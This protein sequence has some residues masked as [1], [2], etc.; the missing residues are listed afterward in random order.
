MCG[1]SKCQALF[2]HQ[3][4]QYVGDNLCICLKSTFIS[5]HLDVPPVGVIRRD[6]TVMHYGIVQQSK[7]MSSAPPSRCV[8]RIASMCRPGIPFVFI[9]P[10]EPA[11]IL[12]IAYRLECAHVLSAGEHI[13]PV[14]L[15][16]YVHHRTRY[17]FFLVELELSE[18]GSKRIDKI[19]PDHRLVSDLRYLSRRDTLRVDDLKILLQKCL[20]LLSCVSAVKKQMERI[21]ILVIRINTIAGKAA[22]KAVAPVVHRFHGSGDHLSCHAVPIS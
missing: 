5:E 13:N 21:K 8:G 4:I 22:A 20:T 16:V 19:S 1:L 9:Q 11:D 3:I 6:L 12:R 7:W 15:G 2:L 18:H 17:E 14:H 10:V